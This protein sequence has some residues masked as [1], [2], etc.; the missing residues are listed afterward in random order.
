MREHW[1]RNAG[2]FQNLQRSAPEE[3]SKVLGTPG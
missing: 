1:E 2:R 3:V